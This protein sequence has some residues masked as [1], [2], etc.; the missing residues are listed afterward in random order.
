MR[1]AVMASG[2]VGHELVKYL[3]DSFPEDVAIIVTAEEDE[4]AALARDRGI[5]TTVWG[6]DVTLQALLIEAGVDLGLLAW[7][8]FIVKDPLLT[9]PALGWI[10]THPSLLPHNRGKHYNFWAIVEGAPFGVTLHFI[11]EGIDT[12]DVIAQREVPYD[13]TDTGESLYGKAQVAM[14]DLFR[15]AYPLIR[16][17]TF[18]RVKQGVDE[19]SYHH[20]EEMQS[21]SRI[22]L[23]Q[24]YTA[25]QLIDLL[26]ARTFRG[27]PS[28]WF[29]DDGVKYEITVAIRRGRA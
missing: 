29:E 13:W 18:V 19:G 3:A 26:R 4:I 1:L 8:P 7:W 21:A 27:Q 25:R 5:P 17:G 16:E 23:D 28:C 12:G 9:L 2:E 20:S 24:E 14:V 15:S 11:D 10:N 6:V 22:Q